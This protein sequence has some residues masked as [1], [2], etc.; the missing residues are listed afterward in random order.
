MC[1]FTSGQVCFRVHNKFWLSVFTLSTLQALLQRWCCLLL[2]NVIKY[3]VYICLHL[4][5]NVVWNV[6]LVVICFLFVYFYC[7][8]NSYFQFCFCQICTGFPLL[9]VMI[10]WETALCPPSLLIFPLSKLK[11]FTSAFCYT[12]YPCHHHMFTDLIV[13]G[14]EC[15]FDLYYHNIIL[16]VL[17]LLP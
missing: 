6:N 11:S 1:L 8:S 4:W 17:V 10:W 9:V 2:L 3:V 16:S 5:L 7:V 15:F 14:W 13:C 12:H